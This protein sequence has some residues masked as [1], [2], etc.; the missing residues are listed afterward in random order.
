MKLLPSVGK[1]KAVGLE[2]ACLVEEERGP[3]V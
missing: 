1:G 3:V 2:V